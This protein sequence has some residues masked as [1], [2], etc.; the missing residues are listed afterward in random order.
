MKKKQVIISALAVV[1]VAV[2][3]IGTCSSKGKGNEL[4]PPD[5]PPVIFFTIKN[6]LSILF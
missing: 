2:I 3:L 6:L 4:P 1:F 5:H